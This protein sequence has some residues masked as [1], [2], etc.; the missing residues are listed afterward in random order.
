MS[1]SRFRFPGRVGLLACAIGMAGLPATAQEQPGPLT[2]SKDAPANF[3][4]S[5]VY[6]QAWLLSRDAEKLQ[7]EKKHG[8]ALEKLLRARQLFDSV[9]SY[10]PLWK[11]EMV[12]G[13]RTKTQD[14]IDT[15]APQALEENKR[16]NEAIAELE[17]GAKTGVVEG[18]APKPLDIRIPTA[19]VP[20][21]TAA[22]QRSCPVTASRARSTSASLT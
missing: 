20:P 21:G 14:D 2:P 22:C 18:E 1:R 5:D 15:V 10:Y 7:A 17:G 16:K 8:E 4:P 13:R 3:D 12:K 11:P 6:F 19:P 9:S